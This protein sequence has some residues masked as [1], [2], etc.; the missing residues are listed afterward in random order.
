MSANPI[1]CASCGRTIYLQQGQPLP[2]GWQRDLF[3]GAICAECSAP[4]VS[5]EGDA[6]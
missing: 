6:P 3:G 4:P 2:D 5:V 1:T